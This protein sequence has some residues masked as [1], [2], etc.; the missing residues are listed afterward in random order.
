MVV[1]KEKCTGCYACVNIC[2]KN[3]IHME[4]DE[5]GAIYPVIDKTKCVECNLCKKICPS[6]N[7]VKTYYPKECFAMY[8]KN[9]E[10]IKKS[11]SGGIATILAKN[12]IKKDGVVYGASFE[13]NEKGLVQTIRIDNEKEIEKLQGSKYVHSYINKTYS[14]AKEDLEN[15]KLVLFIGTPCQ[16]AGL[17]S[18]L[19][20]EYDNLYTV[21]LICHGVPPQRYLK[22]EIKDLTDENID[23]ISFRSKEGFIL[24][25]YK[26]SKIVKQISKEES[27]YYY[28]FLESL[29]YRENCYQCLY[30]KPE[31]CSDIT[32]GDFWGLD[33]EAEIYKSK[34]EGISV[35]LPISEKGSNLLD[36]LIAEFNFEERPV[37]EA[38]NGNSQ[39]Q[40][41]SKKPRNYCKLKKLYLKGGLH[42]IKQNVFKKRKIKKKLKNNKLVY[43]IYK[44]VKEK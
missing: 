3:C 39:L 21:D 37:Q 44:K 18:F 38:V 10:L 8:G 7:K 12:I 43:Y 33:K 34:K 31:R 20:K 26:D 1:E 36:E 6:I 42:R 5:N 2:P 9:S 40:H 28:G 15:K 16:I 25:L 30:A 41:P 13:N 4:E 14:M 24:K 17:K 19:R 32:I 29:F 23:G 22:D 11:T 27:I 35:V